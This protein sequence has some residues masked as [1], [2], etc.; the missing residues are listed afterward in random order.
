MVK[1]VKKYSNY[2]DISICLLNYCKNW[3]KND[4]GTWICS[5]GA[6]DNYACFGYV[7][8]FIFGYVNFYK[9]IIFYIEVK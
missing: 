8:K 1:S 7:Q 6:K 5:V 9:I 2:K 4:K 3:Q